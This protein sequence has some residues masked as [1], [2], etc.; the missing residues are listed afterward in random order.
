MLA[1]FANHEEKDMELLKIKGLR[2]S[3]GGREILK[4]LDFTLE[5]GRTAVIFGPN[6]S[7]KSTFLGSIV[8]LPK[9][10]ITKGNILFKGKDITG[11]ST[12]ERTRLGIGLAFQYPPSIKGVRLRTLLDTMNP[13][14]KAI[15]H[16]SE[17]LDMSPYLDRD[18]NVGF[19]GG[20]RKKSEILQLMVQM[21]DLLL[22]DEPES[23]VD[24]ENISLI[25]DALKIILEKDKPIKKRKR[26]SIIITHTGFILDYIRADKAYVMM[27]GRMLGCGSPSEIFEEIRTMGYK[28]C[29]RC[30][31][32]AEKENHAA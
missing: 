26:S 23:G 14:K 7:G 11:M 6:G 9:Y 3:S 5:E 2:A 25:A 13:D 21:P 18:V 8:G 29:Q 17:I 22:L 4:G 12:Y 1:L 24:I 31:E 32:E 27:D 19:S 28:E 30:L 20:E 10:D 15:E 16:A